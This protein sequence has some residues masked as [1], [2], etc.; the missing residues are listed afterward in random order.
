MNEQRPPISRFEEIMQLT[1]Q[2]LLHMDMDE[3]IALRKLAN[4]E[5]HRSLMA[6]R[7]LTS[8]INKKLKAQSNGNAR[9]A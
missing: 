4:R 6:I 9:D 3:L 2:A 8:A 7:A 1:E 5:F